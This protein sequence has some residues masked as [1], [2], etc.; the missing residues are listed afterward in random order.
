MN[1]FYEIVE[2]SSHL[3]LDEQESFVDILNKRIIEEKRKRII[4][5]VLE[6]QRE[7]ESGEKLT[8]SIDDIL[9]EI[10]S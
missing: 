10:Q 7:F 9:K 4:N 2:A 6:S 1:T 8:S 5:E 3:T